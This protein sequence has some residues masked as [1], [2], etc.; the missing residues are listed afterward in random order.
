MRFKLTKTGDGTGNCGIPFVHSPLFM[1]GSEHAQN[2][3]TGLLFPCG[4]QSSRNR[5]C[6]HIKRM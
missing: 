5:Q 2:D 1:L 6:Q 4:L 3:R